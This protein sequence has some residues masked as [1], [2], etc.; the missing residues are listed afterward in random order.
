MIERNGM[1]KKGSGPW[2]KEEGKKERM[3]DKDD[4]QEGYDS[5][6]G[7]GLKVRGIK[8]AQGLHVAS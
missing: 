1:V 6:S 2:M 8:P 3:E 7:V 4:S 5:V